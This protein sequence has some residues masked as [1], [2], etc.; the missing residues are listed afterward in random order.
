[1]QQQENL[2]IKGMD[3]AAQRD[4]LQ[5]FP[6]WVWKIT[7]KGQ[8]WPAFWVPAPRRSCGE[9]TGLSPK[10]GLFGTHLIS[11]M[12]RLTSL[13]GRGLWKGHLAFILRG[14]RE[15]RK[16]SVWTPAHLAAYWPCDLGQERKRTKIATHMLYAR[17]SASLAYATPFHFI[18]TWTLCNTLAKSPSQ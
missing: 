13:T 9:R 2:S 1:M 5:G 17:L 12:W 14:S 16:T 11:Y 7:G 15:N 10:K 18:F 3:S 4:S 6:L 8:G